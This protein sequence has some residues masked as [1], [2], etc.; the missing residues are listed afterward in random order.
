MEDF[1]KGEER[2]AFMAY[3]L[4]QSFSGAGDGGVC[5]VGGTPEPGKL[6]TIIP[7]AVVGDIACHLEKFGFL[8]PGPSAD[9]FGDMCEAGTESLCRGRRELRAEFFPDRFRN[10]T[11]QRCPDAQ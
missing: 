5:A 3:F 11:G 9:W 1:E 10:D 6:E 2:P 4:G 7:I 8:G